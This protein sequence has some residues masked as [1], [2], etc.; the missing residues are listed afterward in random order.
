MTIPNPASVAQDISDRR[1]SHYQSYND[2]CLINGSNG[3]VY[4]SNTNGGTMKVTHHLLNRGFVLS[5]NGGGVPRGDEA[6]ADGARISA[7]FGGGGG[8]FFF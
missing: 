1:G 7:R 5:G 8:G 6:W 4:S 2:Y 3:T